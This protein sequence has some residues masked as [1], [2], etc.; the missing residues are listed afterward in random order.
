MRACVTCVR[1][2]VCVRETETECVCVCW[3]G[4]MVGGGGVDGCT[5]LWE[6]MLL[7]IRAVQPAS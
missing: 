7:Q 5:L 4:R 6:S 3:G 2:C 1:A